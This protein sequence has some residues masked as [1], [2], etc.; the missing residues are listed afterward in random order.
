MMRRCCTCQEEKPENLFYADRGG[1]GGKARRCV[2]CALAAKRKRGVCST[3]GKEFHGLHKAAKF[4]STLCYHAST[5]IA[6]CLR[7]HPISGDTRRDRRCRTCSLLRH[8]ARP[9]VVRRRQAFYAPRACRECSATFLAATAKAFCSDPCRDISRRRIVRR[10]AKER[11]WRVPEL[12][13]PETRKQKLREWLRAKSPTERL[14]MIRWKHVRRYGLTLESLDAMVL[15]SEGRCDACGDKSRSLFVD[16]CH[17]SGSVRGLLCPRCNT[18]L[19]V[20]DT[21]RRL[22]QLRAYKDNS[23]KVDQAG[24]AVRSREFQRRK[25]NAATAARSSAPS[26]QR[27]CGTAGKESEP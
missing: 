12:R 3:C 21:P 15:R 2:P 14:E 9:K 4:C 20:I 11:Y 6:V 25:L 5:R 19:A 10:S 22:S 1:P 17:E 26:D 23:G 8:N 24:P 7:G 13:D 27:S 18:Q 16:H